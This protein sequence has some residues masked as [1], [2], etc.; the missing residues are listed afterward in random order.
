MTITVNVTQACIDCAGHR[1]NN[2]PI[3]VG[4][5]QIQGVTEAIVGRRIISVTIDNANYFTETP[6]DACRFIAVYDNHGHVEPQSF[7]F[8][9]QPI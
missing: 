5:H 7:T 9:F 8:D 4:M 3:A 1:A 2:C 6:L